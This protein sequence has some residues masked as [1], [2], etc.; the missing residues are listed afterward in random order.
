MK[1]LGIDYGDARTGISISDSTQTLAGSPSVIHEYSTEK[2]IGK[3]LNIINENNISTIVLGLP[4]NMDGTEGTR[5]EKTRELKELLSKET[6]VDIVLL[7]ER[8]T[9][10]SANRIL[11]EVN[12]RGKKRKNC[13]DAVSATIIL[14]SY[15]DSLR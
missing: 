14:Q 4:K 12:V 7:D 9:T 3:L 6:S 1:M 10:M 2:L 13:V 8:C 5:A 11:N 15:L